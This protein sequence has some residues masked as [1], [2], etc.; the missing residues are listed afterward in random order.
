MLNYPV[1]TGHT[2]SLKSSSLAIRVEDCQAE[3]QLVWEKIEM[4]CLAKAVPIS[5]S[6][7]R[8]LEKKV[9]G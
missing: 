2:H 4:S 9:M 7:V 5:R 3:G 8:V 1:D 6:R